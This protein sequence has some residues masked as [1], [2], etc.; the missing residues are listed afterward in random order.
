M[1]WQDANASC[2]SSFRIAFGKVERVFSAKVRFGLDALDAL[3]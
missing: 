3:P 1:G 2:I